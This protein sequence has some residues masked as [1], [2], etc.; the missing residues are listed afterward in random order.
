MRSVEENWTSVPERETDGSTT[1]EPGPTDVP[2]ADAQPRDLQRTYLL[3]LATLWLLDAVL[4]LQPFMFRGGSSGFSGMLRA[5]AAG[6]PSWIA[7]SIT[8]NASLVDH[9]PVLTDAAFAGV[10]FLI[11]FGIAWRRSSRQALALSIV[12]SL[13]VWWF[14][15]GLGATLHGGATPLGGG[16]GGILFYAVLAVLLWPTPGSDEPFVAVRAV[17]ARAAKFIWACLWIV[18]AVLSILG[19]GRSPI[20]LRAVVGD[21]ESGEPRWL[22]DLDRSAES[23]LFHHGDA[24]KMSLA[25]LCVVMAAGVFLPPQGTRAILTLAIVCFAGIWVGIQDFGEILTGRATDPNSAPLIVLLA[26]VYWPLISGRTR[27]TDRAVG[28]AVQ[29]GKA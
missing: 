17:G 11:G 16:P 4:Q 22:A 8:W 18:M 3:V 15:E 13:A 10:Q 19:S 7:H 26:L 1:A 23:L 6:N 12:W 5:A 2:A 29:V 20:A 24:I 25:I 21:L 9:H 27:W 14:G 28:S